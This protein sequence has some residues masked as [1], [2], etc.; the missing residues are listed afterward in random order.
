M[1]KLGRHGIVWIAAVFLLCALSVYAAWTPAGLDGKNV[2]SLAEDPSTITAWFAGTADGEIYKSVDGTNW[3]VLTTGIPAGTAIQS[4]TI[5]PG[6]AT[7]IY[8]GTSGQG[9][10][11]SLDAGDTWSSSGLA[12]LSIRS[13]EIDPYNT[14]ILFAATNNGIFKSID[15]GVNWQQ[16]ISTEIDSAD[17]RK[18]ALNPQDPAV[19]PPPAQ[20]EILYSAATGT[21]GLYK[22]T[23]AGATWAKISTG[24]SS[25]SFTTLAIDPKQRSVVYAGTTDAGMYKSTDAG[26]TWTQ[27]NA[28][29][30]SQNILAIVFYPSSPESIL[31]GT[32]DAGI[33]RTDNYG[34]TWYGWNAG[35]AALKVNSIA[36]LAPQKTSI[37]AATSTGVVSF[38]NAGP[39]LIVTAV[40]GTTSVNTDTD[41]SSQITVTATIRNI[42]AGRASNNI[43]VSAYL[44]TDSTITTT[45]T[46]I[47]GAWVYGLAAGAESTVTI[48]AT[49]PRGSAGTTT[50]Y[51]GA[52]ADNYNYNAESDESNNTLAGNQ[53]AV[54]RTQVN[55]DLIVTAVSGPATVNT[56]TDSSPQITVTATIKN[57]G[58]GRT[59]NYNYVSIYLSAD[60]TITTGDTNIGSIYVPALAAGAETTVAGT[61]TIPRGAAGTT[62]YYLGAIVDA[63][64]G[65]A[66]WN[67]TNNSLAGNQIAVTRTEV[68]PDLIVSSVTSST[69]V[70]TNTD[71]SPQITVTATIKNIGDGRTW[72]YN[73]VSI[74]LSADGTITTGDTNIG[75]IYVPALAAGA[76]TTVTGTVTIPRGA[77]GTTSY[78]LGAIVDAGNGNAEWNETNNSLAGNQIAV[79][80][81][82][83]KPDLIVSSVTSS[84]SVSTNTDS[85]P[86]ITVT[87][88]IKNI[89]DGRTWN[90]NYVSIYL[91]ADS[92]IT[93]SDTNIGS[94]YVPYLA[95]GAETTVTGTVTIPRGAAGTTTYYLGA[96]VDPGNGNAEW[97]E[98]NNWVAGN[99]IA[100]SRTQVNPDLIVTAVSGTTEA[101]TNTDGTVSTPVTVTVKNIG[102]GRTWNYNYVGIYLSADNTITTSDTNIG[103]IYVPYLAAGAETTVTGTVTIPRGAAGTTTY[104]FGAIVDPGNGN[105]EWNETN[106]T[107][108]G[109]EVAVTRTQVNPDLVVTSVSGPSSVST[110]TDN[111]PQITVTATIKN[112]GDG[113]TWNYDYVNIYLS[114]DSIIT[115]SDT[116]I[117]SIYVPYLAA[118]AETT[119]TGT[120]TIPRGAAGTTPYYFGAI[121]DPGNGNAEWNETNNWLAG[122]E[123]AV[124]R[125]QVNSDLIVTAVSGT[126][127]VNTNTDST[128]STPVTVMVKNIG[129]GRTWNYDYVNIYLS[130]DETITTGDTNIGSIYVPYLAAGAETTVSGTVTLPRGPAGTTTYYF[131]AIVDPGNGNAEWNETNNSLA[132]NELTITRTQVNPDLI[133]TAVTGTTKANTGQQFTVTAAIKN[134]GDGRTWNYDYVNIYLSADDAITTGDTNIGSIYVPYLAA[135]AAT[136]VTGTA[137][138]PWYFAPGMYYIGAIVDP[139]NG[140]AEWNETNNTLAGST[141]SIGVTIDNDRDGYSPPADCEDND[142]LQHPGQAWYKD[143]DNDRY[144]DGT[145]V[146]QCSRPSGYKA[147]SELIST[148]GDCNDSSTSIRPG[149]T[150]VPLN[151]IDENCNGMDDDSAT[152][153]AAIQKPAGDITSY[154]GEAVAFQ[155]T[156]GTTIVEYAWYLD[157][158][159]INNQ[160]SFSYSLIPV[161]VH[162][163]TYKVKDSIGRW[164]DLSGPRQITVL[165]ASARV[166]LALEWGDIT[167]WQ[168][169]AEITNPGENDPVTIKATIHNLSTET[170]SSS[171]TVTFYDTYVTG[172]QGRIS[173]GSAELPEIAP[174][175]TTTVELHWAPDSQTPQP[176]YHLIQVTAAKDSSETYIDNNT[177]THHIIRGDR[178]AAGNV[179][180]DV[181]NLN[182]YNQQQIYVGT[183]FT[184]SGYA[185]YHWQNGYL[186]PV[187]GG[188]VT[189]RL[190]DQTYETRT[191][192]SGWFYQE[193]IMPLAAGPYSVNIEVSDSTISGQKQM[194]INAISYPG[195]DLTVYTIRLANAVAEMPETVSA[196]IVNRGGE[197][198]SGSFTNHIKITDQSGGT[199]FTESQTYDNLNGIGAGQGVNVSFTGWTPAIAGN[200]WIT[201]TTDY[202]KTVVESDEN[203]NATTGSVYV[204]PHHVDLEV[205]EIRK[206]CNVISA[207]ITNRG[208]LSSTTGV[209]HFA[210]G[211]ADFYTAVIPSVPGKGGQ[212]WV[213]AAAYSGTSADTTITAT[214]ESPED[215]AAGNNT[216]SGVFDFTSR[217]DLA[218]TNLR[219]NGQYWWGANTVYIGLANTLEAEVRNLGCE[220]ANGSLQ[221]FVDGTA[222]GGVVTI[223]AIAGGGTA[224]VTASF[225][226]AGYTAGTNYTLSAIATIASGRTDAVPGNNSFAERLIV[227]PQLPDYRVSSADIHFSIDPGHPARNEK[228]IIS[229]DIHN[230]G[231]AEGNEFQVAFYEEGQTL[232]GVVQTYQMSA[233]NGIQPG[234]VFTVSP[235]DAAGNVVEWGHGLSGN[236]ALM[237]TVAP[238]A[239]IENDPNDADNSATRKVW[240]NYPPQAQVAVTGVSTIS[241]PGDT[242]SF[243][244]AGSND[245]LDID[246]KGGISRYDWDFGD[247]QTAENAGPTV[248]HTYLGGGNFTATVTVTDNNTENATASI[249]AVMP[250]K[251]TAVA[252]SGGAITPAGDSFLAPGGSQAYTS[253]SPVPLAGGRD[254]RLVPV[255]DRQQHRLGQ[256]EVAALLDVVLVDAGL[257]DRVHRAGLLAKAAE[258]ALEEV[259]VVAGGAARAVLA[260]LGLDRDR[261]RRAHRLAQLAGDAA[262]LAVGI[263]AQRVQTAEARRLRRLLLRVLDRELAREEVAPGQAH[264][265][266]QL[267]EQEGC[268]RN[269]GLARMSCAVIRLMTRWPAASASSR[270]PRPSRRS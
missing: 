236:H 47:G 3:T 261:Q 260:R 212:V 143:A 169:G 62:S 65:N 259:D 180:I 197:T 119:V 264:A 154:F 98:T 144:S 183:R 202:D 40:T 175:G 177:A 137:S 69:S 243:T 10:Y 221:F 42:G 191:N 50:Y 46:S 122:N 63:G 75:S 149:A 238:L 203:N 263:A 257:D 17:I 140:N 170:A 239:G 100:V 201:V 55:P 210:D 84:I 19:T 241:R 211:T 90:Y 220:P 74:Y 240:V 224:V 233:G 188:K 215:A 138:I 8:A 237:V 148:T 230:V 151:G 78:Y 176:G 66:E 41:S 64:N 53:I 152:P 139:G 22:S 218:V 73:Y 141:M 255:A 204:Y 121:V 126:T 187:L 28:G 67:E 59:W 80:R 96:I 120:V 43:L 157:G 38:D 34:S 104:Y 223:P 249:T 94:I 225:D 235:K 11:R 226:F 269:R 57:I 37:L 262:L 227:S 216:R 146:T 207:R 87:A 196:Y 173:L 25:T 77:A 155:G 15:F 23:D 147:A 232:I 1:K 131:G 61:V 161:G 162:E 134:S 142:A 256:V 26:S 135:G 48:T 91:S 244:A 159:L 88:T 111:S 125:T 44:S 231:L 171:G 214:I 267:D 85:T 118:G 209:L 222:T 179:A 81:T 71:N 247:G 86:Q 132:G 51:L 268:G 156:T 270:R 178:Q 32:A 7:T 45:D 36:F 167:F 52:V 254:F 165:Y 206:S 30:G 198:A 208:G 245:N 105:A 113:R 24:L 266:Q 31:V 103:S 54:A 251:L 13:I 190:G 265:L 229:A 205:A 217:S 160:Q 16:I 82:E 83:V 33:Y 228:F 163:I 246:G 92:T 253:D 56:D 110:N 252:G 172:N 182:I 192:S 234:G 195:P 72:N 133:V 6:N 95:A 93:T 193:V 123:I 185:Q 20:T 14:S 102:D 18:I 116:N 153:S 158:K 150:E 39:D 189:V 49:I 219:V 242:I 194:S 70:S 136:T 186:L 29:L 5:D 129:D 258:D 2:L 164:S 117:G 124:A 35:N 109:N 101:S 89:G 27:I 99:A 114:A 107:L 213:N 181:L 199:V 115:T 200:Y 166:D 248:T 21:G 106:N 128:V 108:A 9:V 184:I 12:E 145:T 79:T 127:E 250:F 97:D 68:K 4:I 168:N 130:A 76:E 174:N 58:D 112:I 60:G